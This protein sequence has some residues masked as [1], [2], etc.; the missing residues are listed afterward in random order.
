MNTSM[1]GQNYGGLKTKVVSPFVRFVKNHESKIVFIVST[2][3]MITGIIVI[4]YILT[5]PPPPPPTTALNGTGLL[6]LVLTLILSLIG[7]A[8]AKVGYNDDDQDVLTVA[9][10]FLLVASVFLSMFFWAVFSGLDVLIH[11][12]PL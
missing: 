7:W 5:L 10:L 6:P 1:T 2:V 9:A 11:E 8:I 4:P 3:I 12:V